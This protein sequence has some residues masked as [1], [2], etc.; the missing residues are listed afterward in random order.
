MISQ[1]KQQLQKLENAANI[2]TKQ[3]GKAVYEAA[4][5]TFAQGDMF[6]SLEPTET[7]KELLALDTDNMTPLAALT[8]LYKLKSQLAK[9]H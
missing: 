1:A 5:A 3:K 7:E 8:L 9:K 6:A 2:P 4:S